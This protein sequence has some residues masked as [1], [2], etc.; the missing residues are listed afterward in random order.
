M[1]EL[2][3]QLGPFAVWL[4]GMTLIICNRRA[5]LVIVRAAFDFSAVLQG[6]TPAP[7][8]RPAKI[9]PVTSAATE[10]EAERWGD[11]PTLMQCYMP[12]VCNPQRACCY[13][14]GYPEEPGDW[15]IAAPQPPRRE[16]GTEWP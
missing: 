9:P 16:E 11:G 7:R 13:G 4:G 15:P 6:G 14:C 3:D 8:P 10:A 1:R 2:I 12:E 5:A